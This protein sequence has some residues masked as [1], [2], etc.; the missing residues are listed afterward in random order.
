MSIKIIPHVGFELVKFG[1]TQEAVES[2]LGKPSEVYE[3]KIEGVQEVVMDYQDI[4]VDL[5]FSSSDNFKLG[6]ISFY[7][8]GVLV[9]DVEFI[10]MKEEDFLA[11]ADEAGITDLMLE[12]DF[13]DL[14]SK[15]YYSDDLSI[16]FWLVDGRVDS[17]TVFPAYDPE[18]EETV[19]WPE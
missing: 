13:D 10:G 3:E 2:K 17:I 14:D 5:S 4:G 11:A 9:N 12:D 19:L 15:D 8:R 6:T 18:D 1:M 7:E 16:S